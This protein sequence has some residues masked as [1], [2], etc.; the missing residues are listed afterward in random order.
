MG[1]LSGF[2]KKRL[3]LALKF[4]L[5]GKMIFAGLV[6]KKDLYSKHFRSLFSA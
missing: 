2:G 3:Y 1:K 5:K 6:G 4:S